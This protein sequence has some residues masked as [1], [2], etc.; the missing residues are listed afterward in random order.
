MMKCKIANNLFIYFFQES[1]RNLISND[2]HPQIFSLRFVRN[3]IKVNLRWIIKY[4]YMSRQKEGNHQR[5]YKMQI[6]LTSGQ[7]QKREKKDVN[8]FFY[9]YYLFERND[10]HRNIIHDQTIC[11]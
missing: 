9:D 11:L 1:T 7:I 4:F 3:G 8:F 6:F 5:S 2:E 10:C